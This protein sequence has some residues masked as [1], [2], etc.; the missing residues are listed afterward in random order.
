MAKLPDEILTTIFSLQRQLVEGIDEAA[1]AESMIF[2]QFGE[3]EVTLPVLE[4]LQNVRERLMGPYSRLSALLPRIAE[5][6]PTAP[7]DVLNLLYRTIEQAQAARD[8]TDASV[9]EAKRDFDL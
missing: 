8:A 5:Y 4:Q 3:T 6:Q 1:A 2:E 9:R 7:T